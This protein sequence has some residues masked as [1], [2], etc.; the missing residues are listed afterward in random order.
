MRQLLRGGVSLG[1]DAGGVLTW[2]P[3]QRRVSATDTVGDDFDV[4]DR[5]RR[6]IR[7]RAVF[8]KFFLGETE[9]SDLRDR[10]KVYQV[11][12]FKRFS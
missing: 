10:Q 5:R 8:E 1:A 3:L 7:R 11:F 9:V 4:G 2:L 6:R 12:N